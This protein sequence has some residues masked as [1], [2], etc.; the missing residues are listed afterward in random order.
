MKKRQ[1]NSFNFTGDIRIIEW[2]FDLGTCVMA[3]M[4]N[5]LEIRLKTV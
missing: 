4:M 2:A 1:A 5:T 3:D